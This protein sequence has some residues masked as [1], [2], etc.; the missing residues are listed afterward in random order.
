MTREEAIAIVK[1]AFSAWES[2]FRTPNDDWS[3]EHEALDMAIEA[4]QNPP[5]SQRSMYQLGYIQ[6]Q[7]DTLKN[8][9]EGEWI[10]T[11]RTNIYGGIEVQCSNCGD[12]VMVQHLEDEWYCRH[13]GAKMK[14]AD[15]E[16]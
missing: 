6:G 1:S 5:I 9:P 15:D 16:D 7:E 4:L 2:E 3:E 8:G 10:R 12:G 13:C 14:G 11:G